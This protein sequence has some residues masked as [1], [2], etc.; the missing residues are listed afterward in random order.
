[1]KLDDLALKYGTDKSSN[2]EIDTPKFD[3][4]I[5]FLKEIFGCIKVEIRKDGATK[6]IL[7]GWQNEHQHLHNL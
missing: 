7:S 3:F 4:N 5:D 2:A 6:I 1:M